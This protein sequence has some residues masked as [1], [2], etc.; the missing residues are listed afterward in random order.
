M[1]T[2]RQEWVNLEVSSHIALAPI[3]VASAR[4]HGLHVGLE[5]DLEKSNCSIHR[6]WKHGCLL[7]RFLAAATMVAMA[8]R[9]AIVRGIAVEGARVAE[10]AAMMMGLATLR[11]AT[12]RGDKNG[13]R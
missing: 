3:K 13:G 10:A 2:S 12:L 6:H 8:P 11:A 4:R 1:Y 7:D 9:A 5:E